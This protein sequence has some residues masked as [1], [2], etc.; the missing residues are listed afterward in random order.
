MILVYDFIPDFG[1]YISNNDPFLMFTLILK[2]SRLNSELYFGG[3]YSV[4]FI[5][6][7]FLSFTVQD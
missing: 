1:A 2:A 7:P 4:S 6:T 3:N 5:P